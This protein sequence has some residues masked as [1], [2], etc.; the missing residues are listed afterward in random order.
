MEEKY[1][2]LGDDNT[3]ADANYAGELADAIQKA[4][5]KK[6]LS[7]YCRVDHICKHPELLQKWYDIG[8]RYL[9]LGIEAVSTDALTRFNK[10]TDMEQNEQAIKILRQSASSSFPTS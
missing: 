2:Y 9:V 4:G 7:S 1:I 8:L 6:E 3:F 10:K 5:I